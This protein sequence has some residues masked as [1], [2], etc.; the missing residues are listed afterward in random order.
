MIGAL[1]AG[2]TAIPRL[3]TALKTLAQREVFA[4]SDQAGAEGRA[5]AA[6]ARAT[7]EI[8]QLNER[9]VGSVFALFEEWKKLRPDLERGIGALP[10]G[11]YSAGYVMFVERMLGY[12]DLIMQ[13][14]PDFRATHWRQVLLGE[15]VKHSGILKARFSDLPPEDY[16]RE[17]RTL[18]ADAIKLG[19]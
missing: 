19:R 8:D 7:S 4:A 6:A 2:F 17:L 5:E 3:S 11:P 18:I 15:L 12:F 1:Y 14:R 10:D 9:R 13:N 16:G